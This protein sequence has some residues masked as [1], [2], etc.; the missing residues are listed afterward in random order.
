MRGALL[1]LIAILWA[2]NADAQAVSHSGFV[3]GR[4]FGFPQ[5]VPNDTTRV[6]GDAL[7]RN[8]IILRPATSQSR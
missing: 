1:A 3:D 2:S 8:E 7:F 4:L 6:I 5:A